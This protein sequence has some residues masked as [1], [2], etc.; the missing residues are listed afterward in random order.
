MPL[1]IDLL[2]VQRFL[3]HVMNVRYII[4]IDDLN[5]GKKR[6]KK[7]TCISSD[8]RKAVQKVLINKMSPC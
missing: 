4:K 3:L 8:M 5:D 6:Q 1:A 2:P 7:D